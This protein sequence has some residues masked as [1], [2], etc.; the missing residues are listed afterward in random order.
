[1]LRIL[2]RQPRSLQ[3][4]RIG[5]AA[6]TL[7]RGQR[8]DDLHNTNL[9]RGVRHARAVSGLHSVIILHRGVQVR[10]LVAQRRAHILLLELVDLF[11][12]VV[13]V[14]IEQISRGAAH[15]LPARR[16]R[17]PVG[18]R[19]LICHRRGDETGALFH[20]QVLQQ[21]ARGRQRRL[22]LDAR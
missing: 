6:Q 17:H 20:L 19:G 4:H 15:T 8:R 22:N 10:Y 2:H 16:E 18:L 11:G 13:A 5:L 12:A 3:P 7:R 9:L 21:Y 1:M 14:Y